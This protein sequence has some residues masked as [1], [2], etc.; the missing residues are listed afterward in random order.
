MRVERLPA[1]TVDHFCLPVNYW[2]CMRYFARI[3][4]KKRLKPHPL[5]CVVLVAC[6]MTTM[7]LMKIMSHDVLFRKDGK[8]GE[9][10][11]HQGVWFW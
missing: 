10:H 8:I 7:F 2:G 5:V 6:K 11:T 4:I 1:Y 9:S 3:L